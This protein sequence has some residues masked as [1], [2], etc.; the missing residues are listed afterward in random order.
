MN[1]QHAKNDRKWLKQRFNIWKKAYRKEMRRRQKLMKAPLAGSTIKGRDGSSRNGL[2]ISYSKY[3]NPTLTVEEIESRN[4]LLDV[5][6]HQCF[7]C[8]QRPQEDL[9]HAHPACSTTRSTYSWT[10]RLNIFPSCKKCNSQK[11]SKPV[12]TWLSI[13]ESNGLWTSDQVETFKKWNDANMDK[14]V[15]GKDD[16]DYVEHQFKN[17]DQAHAIWEYCAKHKLN[18][19]DHVV[20]KNVPECLMP[21]E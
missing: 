7:W 12:T 6:E 13:M 19:D 17:I 8:K 20:F 5:N 1:K 14:L 16:V 3:H 10:N 21:I 9:D 18:F 11:G 4:I 15:L 2:V